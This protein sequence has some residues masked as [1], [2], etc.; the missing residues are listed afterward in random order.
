MKRMCNICARR[1]NEEH[2][3]CNVHNLRRVAVGAVLRSRC[4]A[5]RR[6]AAYDSSAQ[7]CW[8]CWSGTLQ[9]TSPSNPTSDVLHTTPRNGNIKHA[10]HNAC[11]ATCSIQQATGAVRHRAAR[12]AAH[13]CYQ[14]A[15]PLEAFTP[16][17]RSY[18]VES[19]CTAALVCSGAEEFKR[20]PRTVAGVQPVPVPAQMWA[21][22]T[23]ALSPVQRTALC[24]SATAT[25]SQHR[26][27]GPTGLTRAPVQL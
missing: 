14:R 19:I 15:V 8:L 3:T 7:L 12:C 21:G 20:R 10:A 11:D 9:N 23:R 16:S 2:T 18:A 25:A 1:C 5:V 27:L 13:C 6:C 26:L 4:G 17:T 22:V 24:P